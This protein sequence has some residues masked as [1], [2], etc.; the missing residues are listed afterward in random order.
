MP[1]RYAAAARAPSPRSGLIKRAKSGPIR[2]SLAPSADRVTRNYCTT[3]KHAFDTDTLAELKTPGNS[4]AI[5]CS[6]DHRDAITEQVSS[7][8]FAKKSNS[9]DNPRRE[10]CA[11]RCYL[12]ISPPPCALRVSNPADVS[13]LAA[14]VRF[15]VYHA[16]RMGIPVRI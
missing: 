16:L 3:A 7:A 12:I 4:Q 9:H 8:A 2:C 10:C 13:L 11:S 5:Q 1:N 14:L 15:T 6:V